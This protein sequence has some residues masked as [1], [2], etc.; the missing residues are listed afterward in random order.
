MRDTPLSVGR[1]IGQG[2]SDLDAANRELKQHK[3]L[4]VELHHRE[5]ERRA[6]TEQQHAVGRLQRAHRLPVRRTRPV[7]A[8]LRIGDEGVGML[9]WNWS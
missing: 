7:R 3:V 9:A 8:A 5:N 6:D 1:S 2:L 4:V